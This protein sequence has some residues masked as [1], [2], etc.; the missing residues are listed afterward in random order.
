MEVLMAN[1]THSNIQGIEKIEILNLDGSSVILTGVRYMLGMSRNLISY[2][3]LETSGCHYIGKDLMVNFY[4]DDQRFLSGKYFQGL[5]YLQGTVLRG[6]V[7]ISKAEKNMTNVWHSRLGH[8]SLNNM[9][10][11]V[12]RGYI[13][14]KDVK[15]LDFC[16]HCIIGKSHKQSFPK[17]KHLTN[18]ILEYVHSDLWGSHS[19]P[20]SLAGHKYF[21]TFIDDFSKKI[22]MYFLKTKYEVFS[23]FREWKVETEKKTDKKIKCLRTDNEL[24]FCNRHF[25]EYYKQSGIK[26][27]KTFIY[28][29]QQNGVS[30]RM[31]MTIMDKVICMLAEFG[32]DQSF[33]AEAASTAIY[34]INRSPNFTLD[35]KL[36]KEVWSGFK[37]DLG[38]LRTFGCSACVH[39][40]EENTGP[41]ALKGVFVGYPM[42]TKGYRV[43]MPQEGR[44]RTSRN[45]IFNED[46]LYKHTVSKEI[47]SPKATKD[48]QVNHES[49]AKKKVSFSDD[50]IRGPSPYPEVEGTPD[51]GGD[52]SS[53]SSNSSI[54]SS[55]DELDHDEL[56]EKSEDG[57]PDSYILA[58]DGERRQNVRPPSRYEDGNFVAYALTVISDLEVEEPRSYA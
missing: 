14:D 49:R 1:N 34:L 8:M 10:E 36:P 7:N 41:R 45:M 39:V 54:S 13:I 51:Q 47:V 22:W 57:E 42:G 55:D 20:D 26:R 17:A 56:N 38:H 3:M 18:G 48:K 24:E 58:R 31:N 4:K 19:T 2:G 16:E 40:T 37:P 28:T 50:L 53:D 12:K 9:S 30:E 43:W 15:T 46:E 5:Y 21:V 35:F 52:E 23:K 6:E 32:L 25:D 29:P 33:W 44:C 27:H 11:L